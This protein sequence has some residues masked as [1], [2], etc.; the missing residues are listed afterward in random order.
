MGEYRFANLQ[1]I[2]AQGTCMADT[3]YLT[4][5]L[6]I[7]ETLKPHF[8]KALLMNCFLGSSEACN[9]EG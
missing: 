2:P 8:T 3:S 6:L 7:L 9:S 1:Q 4:Q 5:K